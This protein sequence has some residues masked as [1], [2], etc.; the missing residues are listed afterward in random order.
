MTGKDE[1][2][3][4]EQ[5]ETPWQE[6]DASTV[7]EELR[8]SLSESAATQTRPKSRVLLLL[9]LLLVLAGAGAYFYLGAPSEP[10][11][12]SAPVVRQPIAVPPPPSTEEAAVKTES[13]PPP[14]PSVE[15]PVAEPAPSQQTAAAVKAEAPAPAAKA[16]PTPSP[17]PAAANGAY[18]LQAGAFAEKANLRK[19]E[20]V[21]RRLGFEPRV[22]TVQKPMVMTRLRLGAFFAEEGEAKLQTLKAVAP[23]AFLLRQGD[24]VLVYAGSFHDPDRA[25][26]AAEQLYEKGIR[27]EEETAEVKM[28]L[29]MLSFGAFADRAAA[30]EAA[31]KARAANLE[32]FISK[33]R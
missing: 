15:K 24:Y 2:N 29:S 19:A 9:V 13:V 12:P 21:V 25:R 32:V 7:E 26:R 33:D 23:E 3:F 30:Q 20:A 28:A 17:A 6:S 27:V 10:E 31:T 4:D 8:R 22:K 11:P 14:P 18:S 1:F 5:L 16:E